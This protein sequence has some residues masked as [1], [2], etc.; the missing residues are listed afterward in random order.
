MILLYIILILLGYF[1]GLISCLLQIINIENKEN[2]K[3]QEI[4]DK[5]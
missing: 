1:L 4:L 2:K 5:N 3:I